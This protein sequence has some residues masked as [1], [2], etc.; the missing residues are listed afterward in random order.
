MD[1]DTASASDPTEGFEQPAASPDAPGPSAAGR[2]FDPEDPAFTLREYLRGIA[3][4][5]TLT[6]QEEFELW[7]EMR[8]HEDAY[9]QGLAAIPFTARHVTR[10]WR[11]I[12]A[13][14]HATSKL[15]ARWRDPAHPNPSPSLDR[16]LGR[17]A[18]LLER[19]VRTAADRE[20]LA[21]HLLRADLAMHLF[22]GAWDALC[23]GIAEGRVRRT[24]TGLPPAELRRRVKAIEAHREALLRARNEFVEHNLKLVVFMAKEYRKIGVPFID[25]IQ[26]GNIGLVRAVEKFDAS[27]GFKFSTYAAWW[28]RQSFI[29]AAQ[30]H[31]RTVRLPSHI[32]DLALRE[33]RVREEL[34]HNLG[35]EP[36][37][38]ELCDALGVEE[39]ELE[40]LYR[41]TRK[42][43]SL[44]AL[45]PG[46]D[47][48]ALVDRIRDEDGHATDAIND[49]QI[50]PAV[51]R[52]LDHLPQR[53]RV[54][55]QMRFGL[56]GMEPHTLHQVGLKL[57]LSR[58]R[59]RQIEKDALHRMRIPA[60]AGGLRDALGSEHEHHDTAWRPGS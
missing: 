54:I 5:T 25:L 16:A 58:E 20:A 43:A 17:A 46:C 8:G 37:N 13:D 45:A 23:L 31:S 6:R 14:G 50:Q 44:D 32:Y 33:K 29:R 24:E 3:D 42:I 56:E 15:S 40:G 51:G 28:I 41:A 39:H 11:G 57:G 36:S 49:E 34:C 60:A 52:L 19:G 48:M 30:I 55:L 12:R 18:S 7:Q 27:R 26:E 38:E 47:D 21:R 1:F 2:P 4:Q 9:R 35:R 22:D 10:L 53:E 59:V